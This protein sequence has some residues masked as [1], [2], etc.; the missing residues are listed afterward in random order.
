MQG[1]QTAGESGVSSDF[2]ACGESLRAKV[3]VAK[4]K[5]GEAVSGLFVIVNTTAIKGSK[6]VILPILAT[7]SIGVFAADGANMF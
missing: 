2:I 4:N 5:S 6:L 7:T 1:C 3:A